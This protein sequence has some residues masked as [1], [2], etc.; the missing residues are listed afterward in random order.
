MI[1]RKIGDR[2]LKV[3]VFQGSPRDID[4]CSGM[5]SKTEKILK[6]TIERY[7]PF[8]DFTVIDLSVNTSKKP[9]IQPCKG[10][11]STSGGYHC[12]FK[13]VSYNQRVH[14]I[15]GFKE[16]QNIKIGDILQDGNVVVNHVMTSDSE[17]VYEIKLTDGRRLE[18]TEDHKIKTMSKQR[19]RNKESNWNYFRNEDWKELKDIEIGDN[20]PYIETDS[21]F[22][23]SEKLENEDFLIYGLI[24][25]DG[26]FCNNTAILYVD[27]KECEFLKDIETKFSHKIVS[28][29]PHQVNDNSNFSDNCESKMLKINFGTDIGKKMLSI[30]PKTAAKTRRLNLDIFNEKSEIFSFFNGWIST[31]GSVRKNGN[32]HLYNVSYD[33]LRDAQLLLS[34]VGIKSNISDISHIET[35]VRNKKHIRT[36][37]L[38]ISDQESVR[39]FC[40]N[41]SLLHTKKRNLLQ[42]GLSVSKR[43]LKHQ[44]SKVKSIKEVGYRPVYDIEVSNSHE[45]NCEGIKIHNCSCYFKGGKTTDLL[46]ELDVYTQLQECDAFLI[47]SPIHWHSL[48][49][50]I[51]TL[52]DRLVCINQTLS[53][54]DAKKLTGDEIKSVEKTGKLA[55][56][57]KYDGMLRNHLEGKVCGFF[58]HG[59]DGADDYDGKQLPQSYDVLNDGFSL[60][61]KSVVMPFVLQMKYSGVFVPDELIQAFYM[62]KGINYNIANHTLNK[63]KEPFERAFTLIENLLDYFS[64]EQ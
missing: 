52:F 19:I 50:Q 11:V 58:A 7:S 38:T 14:M 43:T 8:I 47:F 40:E 28:V 42:K 41:S 33:C 25:G 10:C 55:R 9:N 44:Y 30:L 6:A 18:I 5:E 29:L 4:T 51:K 35:M 48:T 12:H 45:F 24:W 46:A 23:V 36:S 60:D 53:I 26:T 54:D 37:C 2:K 20:I 34:R 22:R 21:I 27:E 16:I 39:T 15:D 49:S 59:D 13:C 61:P 64:P 32:I 3:L 17:K 57:G 1:I 63:N 62:N 31:D 56:S